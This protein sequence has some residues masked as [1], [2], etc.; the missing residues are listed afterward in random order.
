MDRQSVLLLVAKP[1]V[2][3]LGDGE[4]DTLALRE[5]YVRLVTLQKVI[6]INRV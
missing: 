4:L 1:L 3:L 5:T 2:P 6:N